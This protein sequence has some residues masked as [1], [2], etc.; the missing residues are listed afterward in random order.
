MVQT[1]IH[2]CIGR[3]E[4]RFIVSFIESQGLAKVFTTRVSQSKEDKEFNQAWA[5]LHNIFRHDEAT[6]NMVWF[7]LGSI[8]N[9]DILEGRLV[10]R[11]EEFW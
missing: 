2:R 4:I 3:K 5:I 1:L 10:L 7:I 11:G 6:H 9:E 8:H